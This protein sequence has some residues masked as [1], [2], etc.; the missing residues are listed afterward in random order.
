ML[1]AVCWVVAGAVLA[2]CP[3]VRAG[4]PDLPK[5]FPPPR[6][7]GRPIYAWRSIEDLP[8]RIAQFETVFWDPRDTPSLRRLIRTTDLVRGK[9]VLEIGTGTGLLSL[10]CLQRGAR[11]VLATDINPA[12]VTNALYNAAMLGW[13]D[14]FECRQVP[15]DQP[16]AWSVIDSGERFDLVISNPPWEDATPESDF[17]FALYDPGFHL[18]E[19]LLEDLPRHLNPNGRCLLAYGSGPG[20]RTAQRLARQ[21]GQAVKILDPAPAPANLPDT[22]LPGLLIEV[23]V[24]GDGAPPPPLETDADALAP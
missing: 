12:A 23:I 5:P 16:G 22:F 1:R 11:R 20:I 14:R 15:R 18:L 13:A 7:A 6:P 8:F 10:C 17:E 9:T 3:P 2:A 4:M 21:R 24:P 19:S